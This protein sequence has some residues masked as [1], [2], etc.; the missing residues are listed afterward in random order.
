MSEAEMGQIDLG[1]VVG[2]EIGEV[3]LINAT[4]VLSCAQCSDV[5]LSLPLVIGRDRIIKWVRT[6]AR[7]ALLAATFVN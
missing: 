3:V 6:M 1:R 7:A 2:R 5:W 4:Q